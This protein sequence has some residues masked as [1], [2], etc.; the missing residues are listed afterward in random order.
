MNF[1]INKVAEYKG[2]KDSIYHLSEG[3]SPN[4]FFSGSG[5]GYIVQWFSP[6]EGRPFVKVNNPIYTFEKT[7]NDKLWVGENNNGLHLIDISEKKV[8]TFLKIGKASIFSILTFETKT[9][10]GNS[11]GFIHIIDNKTNI[12]DKHLQVSEKSIRSLAVHPQK[13]ELAVASSDFKIRIYDIDNYLLKKVI[14]AHTNSVFTL[15]YHEN[16]LLSSGRDAHIKVWDAD[17]DYILAT[18]VAAHNFAINHIL[19]LK[20]T[21][22]MAS[23]SMDKSI[24]IW[25]LDNMKLLKVIDKGKHASHGTSINRLF[26]NSNTERLFAGSDDRTISEWKLF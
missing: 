2:H 19:P 24:K 14:D 26:W 1:E 12:F 5:D 16:Y 20:G 15:F 11:L 22:F 9:F 13:R 25:N 18:S 3:V 10:V 7:N 8:E 23:C 6:E 21:T 17:L 4:D